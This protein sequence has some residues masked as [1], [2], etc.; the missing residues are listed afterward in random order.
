MLP[1][2]RHIEILEN[3]LKKKNTTPVTIVDRYV[4]PLVPLFISILPL[5][6]S[7]NTDWSKVNTDTYINM[8]C[9]IMIPLLVKDLSSIS[10]IWGLLSKYAKL[11]SNSFPLFIR[12]WFKKNKIHQYRISNGWHDFWDYLSNSVDISIVN[13]THD[14]NMEPLQS[15][16]LTSVGEKIQLN[17]I[18]LSNTIF[19]LKLKDIQFGVLMKQKKND[20]GSI[21]LTF[22]DPSHVDVVNNSYHDYVS[23]RIRT[24]TSSICCFHINNTTKHVMITDVQ[25]NV[26]PPLSDAILETKLK[27]TLMNSLNLFACPKNKA[28]LSKLCKRNQLSLLFHGSPGNGKTSLVMS[29][30]K[31]LR[32]H[33]FIVDKSD[34][35]KFFEHIGLIHFPHY[36]ILFDDIDFW[37]MQKRT[38]TNNASGLSSPN[39]IISITKPEE[40]KN[41]SKTYNNTGNPLLMKLMELLDGWT[42]KND[43]VFVF[44]TNYPENFDS[45]LFRPGRISL[46]LKME[47]MKEIQM[48]DQFMK[49]IYD[50]DHSWRK[51]LTED[52]I[53]SLCKL[54]LSLATVSN[55]ALNISEC[56]DFIKLLVQSYL[57]SDIKLKNQ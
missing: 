34:P 28:K 10:S 23:N 3:V 32:R 35:E 52:Q 41:V 18:I 21:F 6:L 40:S 31:H 43:V 27:Q 36:V 44:T 57:V 55:L 24:K 11:I 25:T 37:D 12:N 20:P 47:G 30:A 13:S 7:S 4:Q 54:N 46:N 22:S 38:I 33:V 17:R 19:I 50:V 15:F 51:Q 16:N 39:T 42:S 53:Q 49:N 14:S 9:G 2:K 56:E 48:W 8:F 45:A 29:I 5:Y 26:S 1:D